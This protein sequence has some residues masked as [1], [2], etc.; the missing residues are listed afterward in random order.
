VD[1]PAAAGVDVSLAHVYA[2]QKQ[3]GCACRRLA[4]RA[5]LATRTSR[6]LWSEDGYDPLDGDECWCSCHEAEH[7]DDDEQPEGSGR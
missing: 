4:A 2:E 3:I 5:C 6:S 1:E 7:C